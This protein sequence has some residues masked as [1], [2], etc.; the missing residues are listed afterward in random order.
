M[1]IGNGFRKG[2]VGLIEGFHRFST[3]RRVFSDNKDLSGYYATHDSL[4]REEVSNNK[5]QTIILL[6]CRSHLAYLLK[7]L[8][9][10]IH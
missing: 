8:A 7:D 1:V 10:L 9:P 2:S 5:E 6:I 3:V 4:I